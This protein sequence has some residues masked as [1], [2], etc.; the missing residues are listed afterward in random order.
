MLHM[1]R[2]VTMDRLRNDLLRPPPHT[3]TLHLLFNQHSNSHYA[4]DKDSP[5]L[6]LTLTSLSLPAVREGGEQPA[7]RTPEGAAE[8]EQP[9]GRSLHG[10]VQVAG[11][12][13]AG[14]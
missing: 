12:E 6:T 10:S 8:F 14:A 1:I 7:A 3:S 2:F 9:P 11:E 5:S 13:G 4:Y